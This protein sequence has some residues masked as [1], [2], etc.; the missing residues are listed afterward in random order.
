MANCNG[1]AGVNGPDQ[2]TII[3]VNIVQNHLLTVI[4]NIAVTMFGNQN[5]TSAVNK[6][7]K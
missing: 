6:Q 5:I 1:T 3:A 7:I 2:N 4:A